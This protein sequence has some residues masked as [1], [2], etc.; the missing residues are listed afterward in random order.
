MRSSSYE[1]TTVVKAD[2]AED[3]MEIVGNHLDNYIMDAE[4]RGKSEDG[5]VGGIDYA[6][7]MGAENTRKK[8]VVLEGDDY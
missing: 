7:V 2:S 1:A 8:A 5:P 4:E 6:E 3:A